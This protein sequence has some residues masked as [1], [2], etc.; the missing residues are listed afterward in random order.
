M[1]RK[2]PSTQA[3]VCLEAAARHESFTKAAQE[4]A[5]TQ[6]AVCRQIASLEQFLGVPLFRRTRRG[7][8]LTEAGAAYS[9]RIGQ[10]LDAVERDTLALMAHPGIA[11]SLDLAVVPTFA[12]RW[13]VPRLPK[14]AA[15]Y[16]DLVLNLETRTR[17][18]LFSDGEFDAALY[19][20]TAEQVANW[21]GTEAV[22]LLRE[23]LVPVCSPSL[24]AGKRRLAPRDLTLLPL[25]QQST[26]PHAW[27]EWF[28][29]HGVEHPGDSAGPRYELFSMLAMAAAHGM[30]L[31]LMPPLLI[32]AELARG[33]LVVA[34]DRPQ[35]GERAYY[36]VTP[37]RKAGD[38]LVARLR[39][40]IATE[41]SAYASHIARA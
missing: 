35:R 19:A 17:P 30:G 40:W 21:P 37:E 28:A 18:F 24:M 15:A 20:G 10:R 11:G 41:A 4:L 31:A 25:L 12:T 22:E 1:K 33:E 23:D 36:L 39:D 14:L 13:L 9:R 26:R 38:P 2:I 32:E 27:R 34:C 29:A 3:L 6:S 5:L 8:L 7:V 16:P